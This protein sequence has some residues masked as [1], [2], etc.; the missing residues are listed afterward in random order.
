M[1]DALRWLLPVLLAFGPVPVLADDAEA[2]AFFEKEVRPVLVEQCGKCHS[3]VKSEG[4]LSLESAAMLSKGGDSGRAIVP[5]NP[6]ASLLIKAIRHEGDIQMPPEKK[7]SDRQIASLTHWVKLGAP[8][9][10]A[11]T[12]SGKGDLGERQRA[13]W[14]FQPVREPAVPTPGQPG[15]VRTP[16]DAFV[17]AGL[18]A[19]GLPPAPPADRRTLIRRLTWDLTG[20]PPA[21]EDVAAF[22]RDD[23]PDAV[24]H[25]VDRLLASPHYG[26]Q[27]GRHWL[28][29]ARY[30]D[31]KG[32][33]YAREERFWTQAW[34]YR[35]WVVRALN[36]DL[37]YDQFVTLQL[38]GDQVATSPDDLAAMG[39]LTLGRRFLG[40]AHDIVD[41]RIDAVS[42]GMLGLTVACARCHDHKYD[43]VPTKDYYSLYG[44]F[45]SSAEKQVVLPVQ[46]GVLPDDAFHKELQQ[47]EEKRRTVLAEKRDEA[48]ARARSRVKEYLL[49]QL[50]LSKYPAEGFDVVLAK[51]DLIPAFIRQWTQHLAVAA[52]QPEPVFRAWTQF[53]RL[54]AAE[55]SQKSAELA[56]ALKSGS[57]GAVNP[58]VLAVLDPTPATMR[59]L[60]ERYGTLFEQVEAEWQALLKAAKEGNQPAPE[61]LPDP[62]AE[63]LRQVLYGPLSPSVVPDEAIVNI[64]FFFDSGTLGELWKL[65]AEV[66]R[67][68]IQSPKSPP[69]AVVLEDRTPRGNPRVFKRG[70]PATP[71]DEI[72]RQFLEIL[73]GPER[74]PFAHGTGRRE[75]A[76]AIVR[77][78]NPLTA[79]VIVNRIWMH[80]FGTGLVK[81]P[82]DF[83]LRA[84]PP[85]HPELLDW[86]ATRLVKEGWSLKWLHRE[87]VLSATYQQAST[88]PSDPAVL[89]RARQ[90]DPE[91]RLLWRMTPHRLTFEE[92]RDGML[93]SAGLLDDRM[94]GKPADLF[95]APYPS[96][97][98]V[99]GLIDRQFLAGVLRAFDF[100]NPDLHIPQRSETTVP[101]QALFL[102]N[103][104]FLGQQAKGL[105]ESAEFASAQ[106][107]E[108]KVDVLYRQLYQRPANASQRAAAAGFV[109][110]IEAEARETR[111]VKP[112]AWE[113]GYGPYDPQA[114]VLKSF[115][116]LPHFD[117]S[118]WQGGPKWP[119]ATL[120][121]AQ[122]TATGGHAG[123]DLEHAVVRRWVAPR[124]MTIAIR[125]AL[126]HPSGAGDGVRATLLVGKHGRVKTAEIHNRTEP[127][128]VERIDVAAGEAVDFVVDIRETLNHDE[129]LWAPVIEELTPTAAG[130]AGRWPAQEDFSITTPAKQ[131]SAWEQLALVLLISNDFAFVD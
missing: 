113:Y 17:L 125:G 89:A 6:D 118:A 115:Q 95:A 94:G 71:G 90:L 36:A 2:E 82:S 84:D 88:G 47:R 96:R 105:T 119:D 87:I 93:A 30:A 116:K 43:P 98:T 22:E 83:G 110:A 46:N 38:A 69:V 7:L 55:F 107:P 27:W 54:P 25:L 131:L 73:S 28:D 85:S 67:W 123:N 91:N 23:R 65:Q 51:T 92:L 99:Y 15:W 53:A 62:A 101:Q 106:T 35:D 128:A 114:G 12:L 49:A 63:E 59:E 126:E 1:P 39:F 37:P 104:P 13:H 127:F 122:L 68:L 102:L 9:P 124:N 77:G 42:R 21:P 61:R 29:V 20:L 52:Q 75:L 11:V 60:V 58:R 103:H 81:T 3:G 100:A 120:G 70:N 19:R 8:W 32:Y 26:E 56:A 76:E 121:W 79:R 41:D 5:G 10:K 117:G 72:P 33:V 74:K 66:D 86:L 109:A 112:N 34:A 108:D 78:D 57:L 64:E 97:R 14:A 111:P 4:G 48:S 130:P 129:F 45:R 24:E 16:V 44:V 40:V 31:T 18:E 80:H 50:E